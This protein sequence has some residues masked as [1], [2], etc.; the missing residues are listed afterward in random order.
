MSAA[1]LTVRI[2]SVRTGCRLSTVGQFFFGARIARHYASTVTGDCGERSIVKSGC[3]EGFATDLD[4]QQNTFSGVCR[5]QGVAGFGLGQSRLNLLYIYWCEC[6]GLI[7]VC[8]YN[9][10]PGAWPGF[11]G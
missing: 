6:L 7:S 2:V 3:M 10:K 4:A 5:D 9:K 1:V 11:C 8:P